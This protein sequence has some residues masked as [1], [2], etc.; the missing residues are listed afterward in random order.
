MKR[1]FLFLALGLM[2][3]VPVQAVSAGA[4][5]YE[6]KAQGIS[7][8]VPGLS[9]EEIVVEESESCVSFFHRPSK[10]HWGGLIG[11]IEVVSP[12]SHMFSAEYN[13]SAYRILAMGKDRVFLWKNAV[14]GVNSGGEALDAYLKASSM[15]SY[16]SLKEHLEIVYTDEFG[17][18][19]V[20]TL[21]TL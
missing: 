2:L 15:L 3:L 5:H 21:V 7:I 17:R 10:E 14:G 16:D 8:T 9:G 1:L 11:A 12:R 19:H 13:S 20:C 18:A 6:N 4:F